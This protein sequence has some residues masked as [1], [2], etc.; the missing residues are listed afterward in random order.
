MISNKVVTRKIFNGIKVF[1][2]DV[3]GTLTDGC[4]YYSA[5]G[6]EMKKFNHKDGRGSLLLKHIS[7]KFG[8]ITGENTKIVEKR[9]EKL[10]ADYCFIGID[11]KLS[12][13]MNFCIK[14]KLSLDEVAYI[15]DD[16]NDLEIINRVGISFAV[17][18]AIH[19]IKKAANYICSRKGGDAAFRE[20]V[21]FLIES[22]E[23]I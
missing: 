11:D 16:T 2:S 17:N 8:I 18:D 10:Q 7:I 23:I 12:F 20:A 3:D 5:I 1:F 14:E 6:E 4:T 15:G 13:I 21:D 9:A 19:E 22:R